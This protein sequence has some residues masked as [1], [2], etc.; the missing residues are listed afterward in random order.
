MI[1]PAVWLVSKFSDGVTGGRFI[2]R[3]WDEEDPTK[4]R[5]DTQID[6]N[7]M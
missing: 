4:A 6:P 1:E 5:S 3:F 2:A 7:I